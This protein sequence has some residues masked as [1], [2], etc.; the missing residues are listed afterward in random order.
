[1]DGEVYAFEEDCVY[2]VRLLYVFGLRWIDWLGD[3]RLL[4]YCLQDLIEE[5]ADTFVF[6]AKVR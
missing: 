1:M 4:D 3:R 2:G 5:T 6:Y